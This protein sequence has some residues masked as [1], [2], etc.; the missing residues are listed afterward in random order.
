[1]GFIRT[2]SGME[3]LG[4]VRGPAMIYAAPTTIA[5]PTDISQILRLTGA[6]TNE[7]QTITITGTPTGGSFALTFRGPVSTSLA[8]NATAAQVQAALE[9]LSTIGFGNVVCA[10]GPLPGTPVTVTFQNNLAAMNVSLLQVVAL[11][12]TGGTT[13]AITVTETTP[14]AGLYDPLT[15]WFALGGTKDGVSPTFND[16]E[17][18][19]TIDQTTSV[20]GSL[21]NSQDWG[22]QTSLVETTLENLTLALD[23][24]PVTLNTTPASGA[25]KRMGMGAPQGRTIR[26]IAIIHRR[27]VGSLAGKLRCHFYR[28]AQ[29]RAGNE[30]TLSYASTGEQQR[31]PL[32]MRSIPDPTVQDEFSTHGY[33]LDQV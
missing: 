13:P 5:P 32:N 23:M 3:Q 11:A 31:I 1:M 22:F 12:L 27:G 20:V 19:F 7:V 16:G 6:S 4:F 30:V 14:G 18:E 28:Q 17:E 26:R 8:F 21:A 9:P 10:G 24:G 2:D 33:I 15:P 29:R 25:E